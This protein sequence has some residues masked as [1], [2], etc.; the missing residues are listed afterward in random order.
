MEPLKTK[1]QETPPSIISAGAKYLLARFFNACTFE[2]IGFFRNWENNSARNLINTAKASISS[3]L[4]EVV[5][6]K[7]LQSL[8]NGVQGLP[9]QLKNVHWDLIMGLGAL[10]RMTPLGRGQ[11]GDETTRFVMN[12][13][14][15]I[16]Q[17]KGEFA[18]L[19][20]NVMGTALQLIGTLYQE[21]GDNKDLMDACKK[22]AFDKIFSSDFVLS[23]VLSVDRGEASVMQRFIGWLCSTSLVRNIADHLVTEHILNN[24][25]N[26][27]LKSEP[28]LFHEQVIAACI[29]DFQAM[30]GHELSLNNLKRLFSV[31][32][33]NLSPKLRQHVVEFNRLREALSNNLIAATIGK[34][35]RASGVM[36][37]SS[38]QLSDLK[39]TLTDLLENPCL[40]NYQNFAM[41]CLLL[42]PQ[43]TK[44]SESV[45]NKIAALAVPHVQ[46]MI[47][48]GNMALM[49][50]CLSGLTGIISDTGEIMLKIARMCTGNKS[51]GTEL[52]QNLT[53]RLQSLINK[54]CTY[55]AQNLGNRTQQ[56]FNG[57]LDLFVNHP[58]RIQELSKLLRSNQTPESIIIAC[59]DLVQ[60]WFTAA[61]PTQMAR[62]AIP[63]VIETAQPVE[64]TVVDV[65]QGA[66][67]AV[68]GHA[69][70]VG[71]TVIHRVQVAVNA[72]SS[73][74]IGRLVET[75]Q[76][77]GRTVVDVAQGATHAVVGHA[78][79]VRHA[80]VHRVQIA[81]NAASSSGIGRLLGRRFSGGM[82]AISDALAPEIASAQESF[83]ELVAQ[84][85]RQAVDRQRLE[86]GLRSI[87]GM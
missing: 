22:W 43:A 23:N 41:A 44:L 38:K 49:R 69:Q 65:A 52:V 67:H 32:N 53:P 18:N 61:E 80:V 26:N 3:K 51:V 72:A 5:F 46:A 30:G 63:A 70:A 59:L 54:T 33:E 71:H 76:S 12:V 36:L 7:G 50:E 25:D 24:P 81:V 40:E 83:R 1:Q 37:P 19:S 8:E 11:L 35:V 82:S 55:L 75:A 4:S 16:A 56:A 21:N 34:L 60:A 78:Q 17:A 14:E 31:S 10:V 57:I 47:K 29:K 9:K 73:S 27:L 45:Q 15:G 86:G 62:K 6:S 20:E 68:A 42:L 87:F 58:E 28:K 64:H 79:A 39:R 74:G 84:P 13:L 66:T 85:L 77:V 48:S 2:K